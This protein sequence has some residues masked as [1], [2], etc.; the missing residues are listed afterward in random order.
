MKVL[1][2]GGSSLANGR[3]L[4]NALT[5]IQEE[6][7][8]SKIAVVVS[9]RAKS[10]D[11]LISLYGQAIRGED[12]HENLEE[13]L[14]YQKGE[15][16]NIQNLGFELKDLFRAIALLGI[17]S[18]NMR[19]KVLAY[20]ELMSAQILVQLLQKRGLK[21]IVGDARNFIRVNL[22][23]KTAGVNIESSEKDTR[24]FF[25]SLIPGTIPVITGFLASDSDGNTVTLGRNGS[26]YSASLVANFIDAEELQ[27]WTDVN[28][29]YSASPK[30]VK[31]AQHIPNLS[32]K[33]ANELA[34]FGVNLLHPKTILP[35]AQKNIPLK[36]Y[37][38]QNPDAGSTLIND[39]GSGKG[40][41]AVSVLEEVALISISGSELLGKVGID[42]RIFSLLSDNE[43]SIRLISQ[44]SSERGIGFVIDKE[45]AQTA[46]QLLLEEFKPELDRGGVSKIE[47]N[48]DMAVIA[49]TG[50][51][52]YALEKAIHSL[53]RN[54]IWL[55]LISN[56]ISGEHI[57]LVID[58]AQLKKAV[59]VVH[60]HVLGVIKT[61]NLFAL[62]KGTVGGAL[63][64]QILQTKEET[65]ARR[66]LKI[67]IVGIADSQKILFEEHGLNQNW[68]QR[69]N[70]SEANSSIAKAISLVQESGLENV[71]FAD[72]TSSNEITA[73]YE[74]I[75]QAGYDIVASNKKANSG[76]YSYYDQ[77]RK[78]LRR[79]GRVFYY[80]TNVGAGLPIIDTLK[81]LYN[82][83]D[84]VKKVR[85]VFSGSLSYVFNNYSNEDVNFS[86]ILDKA[87]RQG[88][89]EPDPREDLG[90]E[91]VA[92]KLIIL[93]REIG[94]KVEFDEVEIQNL[95]P[96]EL[97]GLDNYEEFIARKDDLNQHFKQ[98]KKKQ[99]PKSVLRY[100]GE[101]DVDRGS[102]KV[103][104]LSVSA[105]SPLGNIKNADSIFE[106]YTEG[107]GDQPIVIQG[108][109]AGAAVTAGGVYSDLLRIGSLN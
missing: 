92:R 44:A 97:R 109:G 52:N 50:R 101:L 48:F 94:L 67:N 19:D 98:I 93:A 15:G 84:S 33:E 83:A 34:N 87:K 86:E 1:K 2:F 88:L 26:N 89:T 75:I 80:E 35:L 4:E 11:N 27:N 25:E 12:Y 100:V 81:N 107:Y 29:I 71:V 5:I 43:I 31:D 20:G 54:K 39:T 53:R 51:H 40:I 42:A 37:N 9:A 85:G 7:Q 55:H 64:D 14:Q 65:I 70:E 72:N 28:G 6:A 90:G 36:I 79:K 47:L 73:S 23:A 45:D 106:I 66:K 59:N 13:F 3:A 74:Q 96:Q 58:K 76:P 57:S 103:E 63:I 61:I 49:I 62:G 56:S 32:Y 102:L 91:D 60:N 17:D 105:Q 104:L 38:T 77:L 24:S 22:K 30:W 18:Q 108:A 21:A 95:I 41:K 99:E 68:R 10:T 46:H 16:L 69:L 8:S 82:S 78:E